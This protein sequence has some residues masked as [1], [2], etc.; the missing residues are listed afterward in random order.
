MAGRKKKRSVDY[1]P[2]FVDSGKTL[3]TLEKMFGND[4]YSTPFKI[5]ELLAGTEEH[6]CNF[7]QEEDWFYICAKLNLEEERALKVLG[8]MAKLDFINKN[9][10]ENKVLWCQKLV[11]NLGP[12]YEKRKSELP[13]RPIPDPETFKTAPE[14]PQSKVKERKV[15]KEFMSDSIEI[16][17]ANLLFSKILLRNPEHKK[18]DFQ[19]WA[20][21]FDPIIRIDKRDP[22]KIANMIEWISKDNGNGKGKWKGWGAVV[23]S[24]NSIRDN[25]DKIAIQMGGDSEKHG[26]KLCSDSCFSYQS[27]K[28][29]G[30][31]KSGKKCGAYCSS[32][33]AGR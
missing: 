10:Y 14:I 11:D 12:V 23:L 24:P 17:L 22:Q 19:K 5:L 32:E 8:M 7:S 20:K 30:K 3:F 1:F 26:S 29:I 21:Q 6:F 28:A 4:G 33:S 9:L 13:K 16:R 15:K 27:C 31:L 2:H 25:H 18:P